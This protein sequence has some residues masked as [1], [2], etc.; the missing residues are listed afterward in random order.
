MRK[1]QVGGMDLQYNPILYSW[2]RDPQTLEELYCRDSPIG[3]R[4]LSPK[5]S[6]SVWGSWTR[7]MSP[8]E[9]L[10]LKASGA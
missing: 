9:H 3:V 2:V 6:S 4:V 7:K 8:S 10:A 1:T 5:A